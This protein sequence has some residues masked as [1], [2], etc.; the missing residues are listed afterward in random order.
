MRK[1]EFSVGAVARRCG[2]SVRS[3]QR[4]AAENGTTL[5]QIMDDARLER[6]QD[7]LGR[8]PTM[9]AD[10]L[11]AE[12]GYSDARSLRRGLAKWGVSSLSD[13]R[14]RFMFS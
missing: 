10:D 14:R 7:L 5:S 4:V 1:R 3:A 8:N 9:N 6:L 12:V 11:A 2:L 13:M